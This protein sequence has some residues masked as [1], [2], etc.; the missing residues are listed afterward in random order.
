[1]N[2]PRRHDLVWLNP[3]A[4]AGSFVAATDNAWFAR[5]WVKQGR[6]LVMARQSADQSDDTVALG[7]TQPP[8]RTR[9]LLQ[10]PRSAII[11]HTRPL[12][13]TDTIAYAPQR[14]REGM[15]QLQKVFE[16]HHA[17]A[18]V[19]GSLS[20]QAA[21]CVTFLDAASDLDLLI[22]CNPHTQ[23]GALLA[24]LEAYPLQIP[25]IDGE[26]LM[27]DGWATAWRELASAV[28]T[29]GHLRVLAKS[30]CEARLIPVDHFFACA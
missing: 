17:V 24:A 23:L 11:R 2:A 7:F 5:N 29:G 8:M 25:R 15:H 1:M 30:D 28:R 9:I 20:F 16:Q 14:W 22:E 3:D 12:L 19:Y 27:P 18:R 4:D 26:V 21:S 6:P 10:V 13:L